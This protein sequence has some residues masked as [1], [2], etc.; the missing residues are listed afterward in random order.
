MFI[1][2]QNKIL[3][4]QM[5]CFFS[6][7]PFRRDLWWSFSI[8]VILCVPIDH[9]ES[10]LL[11]GAACSLFGNRLHQANRQFVMPGRA[12]GSSDCTSHW[13]LTRTHRH[14]HRWNTHYLVKQLDAATAHRIDCWHTNMC[15]IN[16]RVCVCVHIVLIVDIQTWTRTLMKHTLPGWA[17]GS[18]DCTL[19]W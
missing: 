13:L 7:E 18:N 11:V 3:N 16:V 19:R 14:T 4:G 10:H 17:A 5:S 8:P 2:M 1:G 15:F 12:A 6:N 9:L